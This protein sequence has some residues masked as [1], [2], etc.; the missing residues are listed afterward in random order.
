M[1][2]YSHHRPMSK[3]AEGAPAR[4]SVETAI[5]ALNPFESNLAN[6]GLYTG[7]GALAGAG[8]GA[9]INAMRGKSIARGALGGGLIGGGIGA[10][11]KGLGDYGLSDEKGVLDNREKIEDRSFGVWDQMP[12]T[13]RNTD[14]DANSEL[15]K[16]F[17]DPNYGLYEALL[18]PK[19]N[20]SPTWE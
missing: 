15:L 1:A 13:Q 4:N 9:L 10:G 14:N 2:Y 3:R 18:G 20:V 12:F 5:G 17:T 6:Y 8:I 11:V 7:G 16:R 19:L